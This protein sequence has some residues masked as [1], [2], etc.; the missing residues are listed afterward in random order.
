MLRTIA[1]AIKRGVRASLRAV[2]R[3][4]LAWTRPATGPCVGSIVGDL[5]R[6]KAALVAENAFLRQQLVVLGRQVKRPVLTPADRL[7]LVLLA[8]LVRG[9]RAG[10][11]H[12]PAG[13]PA[14]LASAGLPPVLA[15][16]VARRVE[17][18]RRWR[19]RRSR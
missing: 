6:T 11:A 9:W 15:R 5:T 2:H 8:R 4:L 19:P 10:A 14:A 16:Q 3:R 13:D 12:R 18:R 1:T 7:R 17:A